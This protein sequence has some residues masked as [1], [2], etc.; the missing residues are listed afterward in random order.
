MTLALALDESPNA[1]GWAVGSTEGERPTWG[2]F[3]QLPWR[4]DEPERLAQF[5][6]WL[7]E[8]AR[9]HGVTH[10]FYE[11]PI[12][13]RGL[14]FIKS[15]DTTAKQSMQIG[16]ILMVAHDLKLT[17]AQ[18]PIDSWRSRFMGAT[19]V[20]GLKGDHARKELKLMALKACALRGWYVEEND[21]AD[22]LGVLD[23]GL[24]TLSRKYAGSADVIFRR[25]E[26]K[27]DFGEKPR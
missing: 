20:P 16:I 1:T 22:A 12:D 4:D 21:A 8:T 17:V 2:V 9:Y 11:S 7:V 15:F 26:L 5:R 13:P 6:D 10:L 25:R 3:R 23:Y 14:S 24:A 19:K 18:V 27:A